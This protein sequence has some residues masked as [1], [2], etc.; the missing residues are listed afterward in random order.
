MRSILEVGE[1]LIEFIL[2]FEYIFILDQ[3]Y[4]L[5]FLCE[6]EHVHRTHVVLDIL[7]DL[8]VDADGVDGVIDPSVL[9]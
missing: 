5:N 8:A 3:L 9:T 1:S 7:R 2:Q 4:L 6:V